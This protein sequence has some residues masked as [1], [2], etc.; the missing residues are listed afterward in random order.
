M[1]NL[2]IAVLVF[3]AF[4]TGCVPLQNR[5]IDEKQSEFYVLKDSFDCKPDMLISYDT[6]ERKI[7]KWQYR[8]LPFNLKNYYEKN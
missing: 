3:M 7:T 2:L 5:I 1:F 6:L 8:R 4:L